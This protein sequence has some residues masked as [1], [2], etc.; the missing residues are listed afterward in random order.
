[1][2]KQCIVL[3]PAAGTGSRFGAKQPKQYV[4][5]HQKPVLQHTID[6]FK[7][8]SQIKH[9]AV[10]ISSN[11]QWFDSNIKL[12]ENAAVYRVGGDTR[13]QTVLN[14]INQLLNKQVAQYQDNIL[15]HDAA[16]CCLSKTAL[17]RLLDASSHPDGALLAIPVTDTLKRQNSNQ[18]VEQTVAREKLWLAQTPQIFQAALLQKAL[19]QTDNQNITDE[20]S[21]VEKLGLNPLIIKGETR[22]LKLTHPEDEQIAAYF[23][24]HNCQN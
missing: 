4:L 12:P 3:I 7:G 19:Q 2:Q 16:R 22:N 21:A 15:V 24:S 23:L 20:S 17:G 18:Q 5:I 8:Y 11:D 6:I 10:I 9:I 14:G 13:A 1:M